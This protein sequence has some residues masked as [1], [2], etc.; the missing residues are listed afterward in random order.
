M[1]SEVPGFNCQDEQ[2]SN[3]L[4]Q[5]LFRISLLAKQLALTWIFTL[6]MRSIARQIHQLKI[7]IGRSGPEMVRYCGHV[8]LNG[9]CF[10]DGEMGKAVIFYGGWRIRVSST[11]GAFSGIS[12][13]C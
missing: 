13:Q 4:A 8:P 9:A 5:A 10:S 12:I 11:R 6:L 2:R 1:C 3:V 7:L